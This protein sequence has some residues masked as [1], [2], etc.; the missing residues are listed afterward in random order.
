V[1]AD[2]KDLV[3]IGDD[4]SIR[5]AGRGAAM[6]LRDR[7]GKYRVVL[8][9]PGLVVLRGEE[10]RA[11]GAVPPR[12]LMSG[13]IVSRMTV[14]EIINGIANLNWRGELHVYAPDAWRML[15]I[16]QG[17]LKHATSDHPDDRLGEVLYRLGALSRAQLEGIL[18]EMTPERRFGS[19]VVERGLIKHEKLFHYLQRQSEQIFYASLLVSEGTY[20][21]VA[22]D[23]Q[24]TPPPTT[25]HLPLQGLLMEGVQRIDEMALFR[26][27]IPNMQACPEVHPVQGRVSLDQKAMTVLMYCDG[28]R[29][30]EE[31]ARSTGLG[32]FETLKTIYHL[33]QVGQMVLRTGP[34]VDQDAVRHLVGQF[35]DVM[36]DIF[37]A[38]A[39][40]GGIEQTRSTLAAWIS[41]TG[42]APFFGESV[43]EDGA[44]DANRVVTALEAA[45]AEHPLEALHQ[46]LHEL[47]A[48]ALFSATTWLPRDQELLLARD[49]N[50][51]LKAIRL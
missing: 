6:K 20:M 18:R 46:A 16:D 24:G 26:Q 30:I 11:E 4:G 44:L 34:K 21:F 43:D 33:I 39:T 41:N 9:I 42:Y 12:V 27:R 2:P 51:R 22:P 47:A 28:T 17:A 1:A 49:V 10:E 14:L 23:E 5:V 32:E 7:R 36:R 25:I 15:V 48:F 50:R 37:A 31:I 35:N 3:V 13:E 19:I 29:N 8:D 40:Y 45:P 38:I